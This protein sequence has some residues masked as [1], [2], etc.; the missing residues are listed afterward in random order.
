M[1]SIGVI[2]CLRY[3]HFALFILNE[4]KKED[5]SDK[6]CECNKSK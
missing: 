2:S 5:P 4:F 6:R 3:D 1:E